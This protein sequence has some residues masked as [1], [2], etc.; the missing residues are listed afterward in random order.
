MA[1][2]YYKTNTQLSSIIKGTT[3]TNIQAAYGG[4]G[5]LTIATS[6]F[7]SVVSETPSILNYSYQGTDISTSCIAYWE[8]GSTDYSKTRP[9]WCN[10]IRAV[11]VGGGGAGAKG[12]A[13][14]DTPE[15]NWNIVYNKYDQNGAQVA[16][17]NN[18]AYTDPAYNA[19]NYF[20]NVNKNFMWYDNFHDNTFN[21]IKTTHYNIARNQTTGS[22]G[23]GGGGGGFLYLDKAITENTLSITFTPVASKGKTT[24]L[25]IGS[26]TW[27]ALGGTN[28]SGVT[29]GT[30]GSTNGTADFTKQGESGTNANTSI[31]GLG[32]KCFLK[33]YATSLTYGKGGDGSDGVAG[34][35]TPSDAQSGQAEY[36]RIYFLTG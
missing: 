9:T 15:V 14:V 24:T 28:A 32:G 29:L 27:A 7:T 36:Y 6:T 16:H 33:D 10:K 30:G 8:E 34:G 19:D 5:G 13:G 26:S 22:G 21:Y 18:S 31:A 25:T 23:G 35:G 4:T 3:N 1:N 2:Y 12:T 20:K 11:L 17:Y